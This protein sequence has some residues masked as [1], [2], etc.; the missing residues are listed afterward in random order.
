MA[1]MDGPPPMTRGEH[2]AYCPECGAAD[3]CHCERGMDHP[4]D[5]CP[6]DLPP[7]VEW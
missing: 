5:T 2:M 6:D 3:P 7:E 1:T 4:A